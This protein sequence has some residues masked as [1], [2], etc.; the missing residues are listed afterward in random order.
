MWDKLLFADI[1][2]FLFPRGTK[3]IF[4]G[5]SVDFL[6]LFRFIPPDPKLKYQ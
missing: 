5:I 1:F 2:I 3:A 6:L 4:T